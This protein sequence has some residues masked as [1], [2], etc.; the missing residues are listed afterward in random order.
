MKINV[1][2]LSLL[3]Q[4]Y[5][6]LTEK[7]NWTGADKNRAAYLQ[8]A[9]A[10]VKAGASLSEVDADLHN[11]AEVRNGLP[12][13]QFAKKDDNH[14][15]ARA[16][17]AFVK[18]EKRDMVESA[19]MTAQIGTYTGLGVFVPTGFQSQ[20]FRALK[21][22]DVL[23]DED[24]VTMIRTAN[25][26][27]LPVPVAGDT[28]IVASVLSESSAD[29][30]TDIDSTGHAVLGAYTYRSPRFVASLEA[31]DDVDAALSV[32]NLFNNF[33]A[34]R[35][36]R[37]IGAD[38]VTGNGSNKPLG[39]IPALQ[40]LG[41]A[42]VTASGASTNT[43][44][45]ETGANSLGSEDFA[46]ALSNL[47][48]AYTNSSKCAWLMNKK[49]LATISSI[50][51]KFGDLL[52]LVKYVDGQPEIFGIPVKICP[53]MDSIGASK[54]PVVLGDLSYW[55]TRL[56]GQVTATLYREAPGLI[57]YG[58]IGLRTFVRADGALLYT[59]TSSPA[60]FVMIANHS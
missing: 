56:V 22:H 52:N 7:R 8:T 17:Q 54:T 26:A 28:E 36:A 49:T 50:V 53:S 45:A 47:D 34:D 24:S 29:S 57:E 38:L 18:G 15:E 6:T 35:I 37:G 30:I 31:F 58:K 27:P 1:R 9:I 20:L 5:N 43:G 3:T 25:G 19:P 11:A 48:D 23:F 42:P 10:A 60:P 59:D 4:E 2:E 39:L 16:W 40:A 41:V 51:N 13:T 14:V 21:A 46:A 44:G 33:T 55:A 32:V 12:V